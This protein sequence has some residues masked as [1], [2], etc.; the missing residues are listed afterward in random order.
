MLSRM[1]LVIS[2][3]FLA[4]SIFVKSNEF[5]PTGSDDTVYFVQ[6]G[7]KHYCVNES[8]IVYGKCY[9]HVILCSLFMGWRDN[10]LFPYM[11]HGSYE[12]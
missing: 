1:G 7:T 2:V 8:T 6:N 3:V 11:Y 4:N 5:A 12:W 9:S 10:H